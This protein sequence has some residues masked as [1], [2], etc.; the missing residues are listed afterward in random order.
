MDQAEK[1]RENRLRRVAKRQ[2]LVLQ[3]SR[4]RNP[5]AVG[6]GGYILVDIATN[7][8]MLG[9]GPWFYCASLEDVEAYLTQEAPNG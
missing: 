1:I 2:G 3:K 9:A 4:Q 8:V 7:G 6:Y 5:H